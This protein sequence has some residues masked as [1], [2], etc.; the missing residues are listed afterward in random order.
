MSKEINKIKE[1]LKIYPQDV[2]LMISL[3]QAYFDNKDYQKAVDT[4]RKILKINPDYSVAF[5]ILGRALVKTEELTDAIKT[6]KKGIVVA[7]KNGDLQVAKE[8]TVF[9]GRLEKN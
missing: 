1:L 6:Y 4:S 2:V 8:M 5:R 3:A 7:G 9:L